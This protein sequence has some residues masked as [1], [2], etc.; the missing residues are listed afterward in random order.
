MQSHAQSTVTRAACTANGQTAQPLL[1]ATRNKGKLRE[2]ASLLSDVPMRLVSLDD[3][4]VD[5]EVEET[6]ATFEENAVL[7]AT[8]YAR[9][10]GLTTLADDSGLEVD[11]L[12]GEPGVRSARYAGPDADD[13]ARVRLL[14]SKLSETPSGRRQAR[15]RC[16][17]AVASPNGSARDLRG[18]VRRNHRRRAPGP[19]RLRLRPGFPV[20]GDGQDHGGSVVRGE[21]CRE[22]PWHGR[23]AGG[24]GAERG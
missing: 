16:A 13:G 14:L 19:E 11:A 24:G 1:V 21:G 17:M 23:P 18:G 20:P 8:A 2:L 3:V 10:S 9:A 15:F 12:G 4:G 7:K 6:G 22:P 5:D